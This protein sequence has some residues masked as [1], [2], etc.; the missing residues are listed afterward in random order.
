M[1]GTPRSAA[2]LPRSLADAVAAE[3]A[4]QRLR[5]VFFWRHGQPAGDG[6]DGGIGPGCLS[7][8]W[9]EEFTA[10][11]GRVYRSAE[12]Y[13]MAHKAWLFGDEET[14]GRILAAGHPAEAQKLGRLVRGFDEAVWRQH[15]SGIVARGNAA[16]FAARPELR[17]YLLATRERVLVEAS[18]LDR[19]WGIGLAADDE[20]AGSPARW[21]GLNLLGFALMAARDALAADAA[22]R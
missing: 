18:P 19:I 15:R 3:T 22:A 10:G 13:M 14:A 2:A 4:G 1:A 6:G 11:D 16:K 20:R 21:R 8:W 12:H 7:Q 17:E 9:P 5:F